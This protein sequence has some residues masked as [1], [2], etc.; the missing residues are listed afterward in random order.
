MKLIKPVVLTLLICAFGFTVACNSYEIEKSNSLLDS[1]NSILDTAN[2]NADEAAKQLGDINSKLGA[3]EEEAELEAVQAQA[4]TIIPLM[5]KSRDGYKDAAAKFEEASKLKLPEKY[6]EYLVARAQELKKRAESMDAAIGQPK[7]MQEI[8]SPEE[9][10]PKA[11][12]VVAKM[13]V[14]LKEAD[15]FKAKADKIHQENKSLFK[16]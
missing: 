13:Q 12:A 1:T 5:E 2:K 3:V 7:A 10:Q 15:D 4:K 16:D 11:Q 14:A 6:A 9:Y 8:K